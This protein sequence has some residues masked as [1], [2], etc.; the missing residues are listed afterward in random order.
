MP[1]GMEQETSLAVADEPFARA[2]HTYAEA[3]R[4]SDEWVLRVEQSPK[5]LHRSAIRQE[6]TMNV[7]GWAFERL[8]RAGRQSDVQRVLADA[9]QAVAIVLPRSKPMREATVER[10]RNLEELVAELAALRDRADRV[11]RETEALRTL[12]RL[13][14]QQ[15]RQ[16]V[17]RDSST[18]RRTP[19]FLRETRYNSE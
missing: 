10:W 6:D 8:A 5:L 9:E 17:R 19:A 12:H 11:C 16:M 2:D 1:L 15:S 3:I 13:A 18:S 4:L 14:N 7:L